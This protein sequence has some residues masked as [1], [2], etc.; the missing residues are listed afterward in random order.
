MDH[1]QE[2]FNRY[3][4]LSHVDGGKPPTDLI[5]W[6]N[7]SILEKNHK[8]QVSSRKLTELQE[9]KL[10]LDL[11]HNCNKL[12]YISANKSGKRLT[13]FKKWNNIFSLLTLDQLAVIKSHNRTYISHHNQTGF[14]R[15]GDLKTS[16]RTCLR[17]FNIP[18]GRRWKGFIRLEWF[19]LHKLFEVYGFPTKCKMWLRLNPGRQLD[20]DG[21]VCLNQR[22]RPTLGCKKQ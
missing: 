4:V 16:T 19:Y 7:I 9:I 1:E 3:V 8:T 20:T 13:R 21:A 11:R 14:I 5:H 18:G 10:K 12:N 2:M 17:R 22:H 6:E 15:N